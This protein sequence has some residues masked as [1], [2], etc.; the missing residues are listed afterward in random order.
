[1]FFSSQTCTQST[2]SNKSTVS[3]AK[4]HSPHHM[5]DFERCVKISHKEQNKSTNRESEDFI[6]L[7][8][9]IKVTITNND[10]GQDKNNMFVSPDV[11]NVDDD[12]DDGDDGHSDESIENDNEDK[13]VILVEP[14]EE[15][16]EVI[17]K[18]IYFMSLCM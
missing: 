5:S 12:D 15:D 9:G 2:S 16:P 17:K 7:S 6:P 8:G 10:T 11:I 14:E 13:S 4:R 18:F 3:P 1:M